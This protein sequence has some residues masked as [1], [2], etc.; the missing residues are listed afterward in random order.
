[1]MI[2]SFLA[3]QAD[4]IGCGT[5]SMRMISSGAFDNFITLS[6]RQLNEEDITDGYLSVICPPEDILQ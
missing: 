1:M 3:K 2:G 5:I 6:I 4:L